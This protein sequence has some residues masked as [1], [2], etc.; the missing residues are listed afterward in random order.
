VATSIRIRL[1][2]REYQLETHARTGSGR[3]LAPR[4]ARRMLASID[5]PR[6]R[7]A[8]RTLA[9]DA[10]ARS[11]EWDDELDSRLGLLFESGRLRMR[12]VEFKSS[13]R[14]DDRQLPEIEHEPV[15]N[16]IVDTHTV[17]IEL[18]DADGNPVPGEPFRIKLP[19]GSIRS[20]TLDDE[21]KARVTG[22]ET[23]GTCEVCFYR[24]DA[25][26]WAPA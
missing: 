11:F 21:G 1:G 18:I 26:V 5:D 15:D 2:M 24:R 23:P 4:E 9:I 12:V 16:E 3:V 20:L 10:G 6:T 7:A 8:L 14:L 25:A 17:S 22:I 13:R 19:D